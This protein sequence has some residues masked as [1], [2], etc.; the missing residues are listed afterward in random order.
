MAQR[1][2]NNGQKTSRIKIFFAP[3]WKFFQS[4]F[5]QLGLLDGYA[6]YMVCK[7]SAWATFIR[8]AKIYQY[9]RKK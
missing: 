3:K 9:S 7:L 6:G 5:L 8:Y 2:V 4:Y 1:A